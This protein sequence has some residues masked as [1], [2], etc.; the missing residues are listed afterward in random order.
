MDM[1]LEF[2]QWSFLEILTEFYM[3]KYFLYSFVMLFSLKISG[4]AFDFAELPEGKDITLV[5][6]ATTAI[7]FPYSAELSPT[8]LPQLLSFTVL[9]KN[10]SDQRLLK[11]ILRPERE[12]K[13]EI[14]IQPGKTGM[15]VFTQL[16]AVKVEWEVS[17][18][19]GREQLNQDDFTL[20]V[21]S[22]KPLKIGRN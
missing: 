16:S 4:K 21:S 22:S 20:E 12:T 18:S 14:Q 11:I 3:S 2:K 17:G 1:A 13:K 9:P 8:D 6:P 7:P 19:N 10:P 15:Y 5:A